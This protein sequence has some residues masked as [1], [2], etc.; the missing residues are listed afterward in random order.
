M[1]YATRVVGGIRF[2][3][4]DAHARGNEYGARSAFDRVDVR[5]QRGLHL[6]AKRLLI[7]YRVSEY[8]QLYRNGISSNYE[9]SCIYSGRTR[10]V[11]VELPL[12]RTACS[13]LWWRVGRFR[14]L[15]EDID[16]FQFTFIRG[17]KKETNKK[18][19]LLVFRTILWKK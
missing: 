8:S 11:G 1:T 3:S 17:Q 10:T 15:S 19:Q 6:G 18:E 16:R 13:L 4:L 7:L 12:G 9:P 2:S 5:L 14:D